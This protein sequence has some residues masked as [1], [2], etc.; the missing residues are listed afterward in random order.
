MALNI[1]GV[2]LD[3][4]FTCPKD[5]MRYRTAMERMHEAS[6]SAQNAVDDTALDAYAEVVTNLLTLFAAFLDEVFGEGSA[7]K[8]LGEKPSLTKFTEIQNALLAGAEAQSKA[9]EAHFSKYTPN[10]ELR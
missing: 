8:L 6:Q 1:N 3:F 2:Q 9:I 10:R 5:I 4:D 7:Q